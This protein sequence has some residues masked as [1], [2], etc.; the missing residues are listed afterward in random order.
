MALTVV[1]HSFVAYWTCDLVVCFF[2]SD[3]MFAGRPPF[4]FLRW[5]QLFCFFHLVS[6]LCLPDKG[7]ALFRLP[8]AFVVWSFFHLVSAVCLID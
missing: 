1:V 4:M 8:P 2:S 6:A 5:F 3:L 7:A